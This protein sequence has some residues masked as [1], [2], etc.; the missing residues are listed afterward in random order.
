MSEL[1]S[2]KRRLTVLEADDTSEKKSL[3]LMRASM[4]WPT[5]VIIPAMLAAAATAS[6]A[7]LSLLLRHT[8]RSIRQHVDGLAYQMKKDKALHMRT[9]IHLYIYKEKK[10]DVAL[11]ALPR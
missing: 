11:Q 3:N 1:M 8:R 6:M 2:F 10:I 5:T 4:L 7:G 9:L